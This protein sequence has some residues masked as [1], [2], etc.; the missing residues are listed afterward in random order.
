MDEI[1]DDDAWFVVVWGGVPWIFCFAVKTNLFSWY[2]VYPS[3]CREADPYAH[4][5]FALLVD[6]PRRSCMMQTV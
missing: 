6:T 3:S 4:E 5:V 2:R 1:R